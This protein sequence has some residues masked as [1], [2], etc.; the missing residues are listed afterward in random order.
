MKNPM[1]KNRQNIRAKAKMLDE[2]NICA[3]GLA[4]MLKKQTADKKSIL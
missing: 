2:R 3:D 1:I 4:V